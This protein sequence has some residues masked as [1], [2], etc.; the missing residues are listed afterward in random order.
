MSGQSVVEVGGTGDCVVYTSPVLVAAGATQVPAV[1][2]HWVSLLVW[3]KLASAWS[4]ALEAA[5]AI[6]W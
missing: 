2:G 1:R 5:K 6:V 3:G 4:L